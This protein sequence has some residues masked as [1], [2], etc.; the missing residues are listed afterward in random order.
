MAQLEL[1]SNHHLT[2]TLALLALDFLL[3]QY[4]NSQPK[5]VLWKLAYSSSVFQNCGK[6]YFSLLFLSHTFLKIIFSDSKIHYQ[7]TLVIVNPLDKLIVNNNI[8]I[9]YLLTK[10]HLLFSLYSFFTLT[11][12]LHQHNFINLILTDKKPLR[13]F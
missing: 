6:H 7:I 10:I 2:V 13:Q 4:T 12:K 11:K 5:V 1:I 8:N 3:S 9:L